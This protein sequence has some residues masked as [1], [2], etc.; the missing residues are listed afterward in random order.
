MT[1][2]YRSLLR[3]ASLRSAALTA[4]TAAALVVGG[5]PRVALAV[6]DAVWNPA[7]GHWYAYV[8]ASTPSDWN[9]CTEAAAAAG[10][11]LATITSPEEHSWI[12]D[13]LGIAGRPAAWLGATDSGTEGTWTWIGG[14]SWSFANWAAGE[15]GDSA[16]TENW[17]AMASDGTWTDEPATLLLAGYIVEWDSDPNPQPPVAPAN[18][19]ASYSQGAGVALT[20]NDASATE[21]GF[22]V[23]RMAA[24]QSW[25]V[26]RTTD[27]DVAAWTDFALFPATT[28]TYRVAAVGPGGTSDWSN[29]VTVTTS[30]GEALPPPPIAPSAL[31]ATATQAPAIELAWRDNSDDETL[32]DLERAEGGAA[33]GKESTLPA[34][35]VA[36]TDDAVHP[37][38]PYA[39]RIRALGMQGPST[40]SNVVT[41][42]VPATLGVSMQ[43]GTLRHAAAAGRDSIVMTAS[44]AL[45]SPAPGEALDPVGHGLSVQFGP[46]GAPVVRHIAADDPGWKVKLRRG[47][48]VKATWK[49]SKGAWPKLAVTVDIATGRITLSAK[50]A[51]F[52]ADPAAQMRVLVA[53]GER[54]GGSTATWTQRSAAVLQMR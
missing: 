43:S 4:L 23:E 22:V 17:L 15:P 9:T 7:T 28:Y 20:W 45:A 31:A 48:P 19:A 29:E 39:Y 5:R 25:S 30:A 52:A 53:C 44:L 14:E 2:T 10:G 33:F 8:D 26:R 16:G 42:T 47:T 50:R 32:F 49:S 35:S 41:A 27:A 6:D 18:L 37:G 1:A 38:W 54:C 40:F 3:A 46:V 51:D 24:G 21:Q 12:L 36:F 34:G 11:H 13:N